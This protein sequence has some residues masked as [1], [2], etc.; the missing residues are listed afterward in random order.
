MFDFV[1]L[2]LGSGEENVYI[3]GHTP[4]TGAYTSFFFFFL[5]FGHVKKQKIVFNTISYGTGLFN[6]GYT[7]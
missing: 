2:L 1:Y 3:W 4:G 5:L 6:I 7:P